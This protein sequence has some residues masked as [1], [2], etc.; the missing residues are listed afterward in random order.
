[1]KIG[2]Q[3][4]WYAE[5]QGSFLQSIGSRYVVAETLG[6]AL[7]KVEKYIDAE[8]AELPAEQRETPYAQK[9]VVLSIKIFD[10][11]VLP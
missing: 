7:A 10:R 8:W 5:F 9:P 6:E 3:M 4:L 11:A 1:M 2:P